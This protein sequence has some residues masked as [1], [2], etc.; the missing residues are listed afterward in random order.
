MVKTK[1]YCPT[2]HFYHTGERCPICEEE[3]IQRLSSKYTKREE[4]RRDEKPREVSIESIQKL[5]KKFT[6]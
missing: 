4:I 5:I 2:H 6:V 3:K 1:N